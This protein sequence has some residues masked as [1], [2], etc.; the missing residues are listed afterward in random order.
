M[1]QSQPPVLPAALDPRQ[2]KAL[3]LLQEAYRAALQACRKPWD[4]AI[5]L[6]ELHAAE[7]TGT[8]MRSLLC[9]G[10]VMHAQEV[11]R[12]AGPTRSF[13]RLSSLTLPPGCCFVLTESGFNLVQA[14][15]GLSQPAAEVPPSGHP[16]HWDADLR[17]LW[18]RGQLVKRFRTR[19]VSQETILLA[20]EEECWPS[21]IDD[22]LPQAAGAD[23]FQ[24]LHD[25]VRGLNRNQCHALLVFRRDGT[26]RGVQW[27]ARD[28]A[29]PLPRYA[30]ITDGEAHFRANGTRPPEP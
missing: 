19:A 15:A 26:G 1:K 28:P 4:F 21:R 9:A 24:R 14:Q 7:V 2:A 25:A 17:E 11:H 5:D 6:S 8:D 12:F 29:D 13:R 20:L 10:L 3:R 30:G 22:P 16:P 27:K 18:W 23:S